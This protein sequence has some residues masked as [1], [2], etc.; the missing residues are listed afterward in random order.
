L[1][2]R[3]PNLGQKLKQR[4]GD[5]HPW[6]FGRKVEELIEERGQS[7][8]TE[9]DSAYQILNDFLGLSQQKEFKIFVLLYEGEPWKDSQIEALCDQNKI[10]HVNVATFINAA[11]EQDE[12]VKFPRDGHWN[13]HGHEIAASVFVKALLVK[14]LNE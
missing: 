9:V 12:A 4:Y 14:L 7:D 13:A 6:L 8:S 11:R 2:Y 5:Q 10:P 3:F 1:K